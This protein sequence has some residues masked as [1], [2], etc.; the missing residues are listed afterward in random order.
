M[1]KKQLSF[2]GIILLI[3]LLV[4]GYMISFHPSKEKNRQKASVD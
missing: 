3:G 4:W 1:N 2:F